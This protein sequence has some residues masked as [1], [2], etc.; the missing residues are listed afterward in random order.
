MNFIFLKLF[1]LFEPTMLKKINV[2]IHTAPL[3]TI[4]VNESL[5]KTEQEKINH[6]TQQV[7]RQI[8]PMSL[9]E[10]IPPTL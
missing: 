10:K 6:T 7:E 8:I 3:V 2:N 4:L 1:S 9:Y 5:H